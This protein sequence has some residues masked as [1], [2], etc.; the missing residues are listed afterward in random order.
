VL[1]FLKIVINHTL[2]IDHFQYGFVTNVCKRDGKALLQIVT[3]VQCLV[4]TIYHELSLLFKPNITSV[5][6]CKDMWYGI[7]FYF[8]F[9]NIQC[10]FVV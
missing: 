4:L 6:A 2:I 10:S 9:Q 3:L 8:I 5:N 7:M 1:T